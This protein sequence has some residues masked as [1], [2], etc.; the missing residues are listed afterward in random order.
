[1]YPTNP[2]NYIQLKTHWFNFFSARFCYIDIKLRLADDIFDEHYI[3]THFEKR[4]EHKPGTR[5]DIVYVRIPKRCIPGFKEVMSKLKYRILMTG[6][7]DYDKTCEEFMQDKHN[8]QDII[9]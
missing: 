4:V 2:N 1:M 9:D 5:Y 8:I 3:P 7:Q 6:Y